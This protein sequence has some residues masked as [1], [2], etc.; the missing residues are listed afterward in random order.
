MPEARPRG[1]AFSERRRA[2]KELKKKPPEIF[3]C[4][5]ALEQ[6]YFFQSDSETV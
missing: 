1:V 5:R 3:H 6:K 4:T 2:G